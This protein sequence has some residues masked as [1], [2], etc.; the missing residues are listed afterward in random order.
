[1]IFDD[2]EQRRHSCQLNAFNRTVFVYGCSNVINKTITI[3]IWIVYIS[4]CLFKLPCVE[5]VSFFWYNL[6]YKII[7]LYDYMYCKQRSLRITLRVGYRPIVKLWNFIN[8]LQ[9]SNYF[10]KILN[11]SHKAIEQRRLLNTEHAPYLCCHLI[12]HW[13]Y[14]I[15]Q[16]GTYM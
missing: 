3:I 4:L 15:C 12:L 9:G 14:C 6:R 7:Y 8:G 2:F 16:N 10:S 1:M 5:Y 13:S 11:V